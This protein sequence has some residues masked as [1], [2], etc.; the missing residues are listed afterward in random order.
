MTKSIVVASALALACTLGPALAADLP[1]TKSA[2]AFIPPVA[3]PPIWT[4]LYAGLNAGYTWSNSDTVAQ[5][6]W[7]T[8]AAGLG[9]S[10]LIGNFPAS[11]NANVS[12]FIGGGQIGYNSQVSDK[13]LWGVEADIQGLASSGSAATLTGASAYTTL[14]RGIDYIGTARGRLGYLITPTLLAYATGGLAYG[15][16]NLSASY[17]GAPTIVASDSYSDLR[18]GYAVGGGLEWLFAPRW[19]AKV[20]YLYY[21]LG[22]ASTPGAVYAYTSALGSQISGAQSSTRFDGHIAR[23]GLNYHFDWFKPAP[24]AAKF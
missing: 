21:D 12:G 11:I 8:D 13:F 22:T 10:A 9:A 19:S 23:A 7:D 18:I 16:T 24:I 3:P 1:S 6:Y 5:T 17:L 2:P 14:S 20:E 4:G 15:Q